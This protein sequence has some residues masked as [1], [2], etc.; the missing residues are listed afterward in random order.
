MMAYASVDEIPDFDGVFG[1][2]G[3]H[4]CPIFDVLEALEYGFSGP[5]R[6]WKKVDLGFG[7]RFLKNGGCKG[8]FQK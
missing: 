3:G 1:H 6:C 8:H 5:K 7:G 2:F 4:F